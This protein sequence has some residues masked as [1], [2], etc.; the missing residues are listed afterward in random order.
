MF[1][2]VGHQQIWHEQ[3][4]EK[5]LTIRVCPLLLPL[6]PTATR[7]RWCWPAR[8]WTCEAH[9][10]P[11]TECHPCEWRPWG[12]SD[13]Q[14]ICHLAA[15]AWESQGEASRRTTDWARSSCPSTEL[16]AALGVICSS[17]ETWLGDN[18]MKLTYA[19]VLEHENKASTLLLSRDCH[20]HVWDIIYNRISCIQFVY[21]LTRKEQCKYLLIPSEGE[22]NSGPLYK[23]EK[24]RNEG[25][26]D[27][28]ENGII[29]RHDPF[30]QTVNPSY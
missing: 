26:G 14:L 22:W 19:R 8:C 17:V 13:V 1:W 16:W 12:P 5:C 25:M 29:T 3:R 28:V 24:G 7:R 4:L 2:P 18:I 15:A 20:T 11:P 30:Q 6:E 10:S 23:W 27:L 21:K 9:V